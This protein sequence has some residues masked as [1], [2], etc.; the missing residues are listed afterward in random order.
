MDTMQCCRVWDV[1]RLSCLN[2]NCLLS[3]NS[4]NSPASIFLGTFPFQIAGCNQ[5]NEVIVHMPIWC[6]AQ[7]LIKYKN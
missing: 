2:I 7:V 4:G 3:T 5:G 1:Q 6:L